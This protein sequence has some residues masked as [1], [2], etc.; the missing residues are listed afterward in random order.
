MPADRGLT[1]YIVRTRQALLISENVEQRVTE[2]GLENVGGNSQSYLGVPLILGSQVLGVM[3]IQ[4]YDQARLY[5]AHD[6]ELMTAIAGQAAISLQNARLFEQTQ[7]QAR[8]VAAINDIL[9]AVSQRRELDHILEIAYRHIHQLV[10]SDACII[11][12]YDSQTDRLWYPMIYDNE[13]RYPVREGNIAASTNISRV[14]TSGVPVL[15]HRAPQEIEQISGGTT[16]GLGNLDR[17]SASLLYVPLNSEQKVIGVLSVQSYQLNAYTPEHIDLL[18]RIANQLGVAI[19]NT[20]LFTQTQQALAETEQLYSVSQRLAAITQLD[21]AMKIVA[22]S[23]P[24]ADMNRVVLWLFE[25]DEQGAVSEAIVSAKWYS[26]QG[27]PPLPVGTRLSTQVLRALQWVFSQEPVFSDDLRSDPR[28]DEATRTLLQQQ[29]IEAIA[30][31][32]LWTGGRQIGALLLESDRPHTFVETETRLYLSLSQ[33]VATAIDNQRLLER[34]QRNSLQLAA[35]NE[36]SQVISQQIEVEQILESTYQ[37]LQQL[38][39]V[40]AFFAVLHDR[41]TNTISFPVVYDEGKRYTEPTSPYNPTS[42]TGKVIA[43]G[44]SILKLLTTD[45]LAAKTEIKG[46][47]GNVS[48]PSA[49]LLYVPLRV[50]VQTIGVLSIQSY[51]INAYSTDT[52][53]LV[54]NVANQVAIAIQNA[55]L[56]SEARARARREQ[57]LREITSR[58]RSSTDPEAIVHTAIRELG[59]ALGRQTFIRLGDAEQLGKPPQTPEEVRASGN[60]HPE[61]LEGVQ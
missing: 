18:T 4:S 9:Q 35:L 43:T 37:R 3:A 2:L 11:A 27:T 12:M 23:A 19:Q 40:D 49:S 50:G 8:E 25:R 34:T 57:T 17:P 7:K 53:N 60:G 21:D 16:A 6:Q 31:F 24:V 46:A 58:V 48:R 5:D 47:L 41:A 51:Q 42:N 20:R 30:I 38:V 29:Q 36:L 39:A 10:P 33:Q 26:G 61:G 56:F 22:E 15:I 45:E 32:P 1:G 54:S 13:Q 44:E 52:V 28:L 14:I 55:R 59:T